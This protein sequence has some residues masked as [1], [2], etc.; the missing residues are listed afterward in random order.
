[1][2]KRKS[3]DAQVGDMFVKAHDTKNNIWVVEKIFEHVDGILHARLFNKKQ[4]KTMITVSAS[5]LSDSSFF[6][7]AP[8]GTL[9]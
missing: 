8:A 4:P 2:F 6:L 5:T 3:I 7:R 1:M 9:D